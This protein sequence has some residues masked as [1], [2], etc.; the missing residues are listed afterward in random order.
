LTEL[1]KRVL[2]GLVACPLIIL[3]FCFLPPVWLFLFLALVALAALV[4]LVTI[5]GIRER[6]FPIFLTAT[7]FLPLYQRS[8]QGFLFWLIFAPAVYLLSRFLTGEAKKE[9]INSEIL[10]GTS[11][12]LLGEVFVIVPLFYV[13][14][15]KEKGRW[16]SLVLLLTLWAS[17]TGAYFSGKTFGKRPLVP[18]ISPNKTYEGLIGAMAGSM[19]I[20]VI[21]M[22]LTGTGVLGSIFLGLAIGFLGQLGDVFESAAKRVCEVKDASNL[23]PGHGGILDRIDSFTF[24]APFLYYYLIVVKGF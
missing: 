5:A 2:T 1:K 7:S 20:T 16:L 3:V 6:Y 15:L 14:L 21:S 13:Y 22:R 4:E 12:L 11:L 10:R 17:D 8:F 19:V 9:G 23:I 18:K 24:A